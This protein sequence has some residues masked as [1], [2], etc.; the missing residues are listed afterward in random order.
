MRIEGNWAVKEQYLIPQGK[1]QPVKAVQEIQQVKASQEVKKKFAFPTYEIEVKQK[2]ADKYQKSELEANFATNTDTSEQASEGSSKRQASPGKDPQMMQG[3]ARVRA[4][5]AAHKAAAGQFG[6]PIVYHYAVGPDG[7]RYVVGG[8]VSIH[9]PEGSTPEETIRNMEQVK[10]A[11]LATGDPSPQDMAVAA[12]ATMKIMQARQEMAREKI[13][14]DKTSAGEIQLQT[15]AESVPVKGPNSDLAVT[16]SFALTPAASFE[17]K[18]A[19]QEVLVKEEFSPESLK[20]KILEYQQLIKW[21]QSEKLAN[22]AGQ[23]LNLI[24]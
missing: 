4:H 12:Q 6:G 3:E 15:S 22:Y 20:K 17:E 2:Q 7:Q 23:A 16:S 19:D 13:S 10:R 9:A 8:E 11:A 18:V 21:I 1:L 5:E 14:D 24:A